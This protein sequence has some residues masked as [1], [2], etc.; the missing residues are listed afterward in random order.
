MLVL[1][2]SFSL[3]F[4]QSL[5]RPFEMQFAEPH[6]DM[7][8][9]AGKTIAC[10]PRLL[11]QDSLPKKSLMTIGVERKVSVQN[12]EDA[13]SLWTGVMSGLLRPTVGT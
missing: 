2:L 12:R 7:Q 3:A 8:V 10:L 4:L 11:D 13:H 5:S 1:K 6:V 9:R